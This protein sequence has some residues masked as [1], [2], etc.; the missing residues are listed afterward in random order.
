MKNDPDIL[1]NP[2]RE[3]ERQNGAHF[4]KFRSLEKLHYV[5]THTHTHMYVYKYKNNFRVKVNVCSLT[6][7]F[8]ITTRHNAGLDK[9]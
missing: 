8:H 4:S 9:N 3:G 2:L 1:Y 5:Y 6:Q 7:H